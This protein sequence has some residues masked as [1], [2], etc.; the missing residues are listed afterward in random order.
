MKLHIG[1]QFDTA[2]LSQLVAS[3][4][5]LI[6]NLKNHKFG[7][8]GIAPATQIALYGIKSKDTS[9]SELI[10]STT[11]SLG[12]GDVL[13]VPRTCVGTCLG[14]FP[15]ELPLCANRETHDALL[16]VASKGIIVVIPAGG[17]YQNFKRT[18]KI[19]EVASKESKTPIEMISGPA[20]EVG[21][22]ERFLECQSKGVLIVGNTSSWSNRG[23]NILR[24]PDI[25]FTVAGGNERVVAG[26]GFTTG[27]HGPHASAAMVAGLA[28]LA[29]QANSL[30]RRGILKLKS[31]DIHHLFQSITVP[32][33]ALLPK[34]AIS[35]P[36]SRWI[37]IAK[38]GIATGKDSPFGWRAK[39]SS[40]A[41]K[42]LNK[43]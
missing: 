27:W 18:D 8:A 5:S 16:Y 32:S 12:K 31:E 38:F 15:F 39:H 34:D 35:V 13:L 17:G 22:N 19:F 4:I 28:A 23:K 37:K 14:Q 21:L 36:I 2:I 20:I 29:S 11:K 1:E 3:P 30:S 7:P 43:I 10:K 33:W 26:V 24:V 9:L 25:P 42:I 6:K 41:L 40:S